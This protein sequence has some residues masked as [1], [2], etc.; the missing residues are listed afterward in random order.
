Q[1]GDEERTTCHDLRSGE[2]LWSHAELVRHEEPLGGPGPRAT[3]AID[4]ERVFSMGATGILNALDLQT[5][6]RLWRVD[7]ALTAGVGRPIYGFAASPVVQGDRVIVV[8]GGN[9]GRSLYA[10]DKTTGE[11]V[12]SGGNAPYGYA[13]PVVGTVAGVEQWVALSEGSVNGIDAADGTLLWSQAWP[14]PTEHTVQP[15]LLSGDRVLVSSGYGVGAKMYRLKAGD[16]GIDVDILWESIRLKA[17]FSDF[18]IREDHVY[19]LDDGILTA[20]A[21]DDGSRAWKKGRYGHGQ[22]LLVDDLLLIL[23]EDGSVALVEARPDEY[24]EHGR[25][26]VLEGKTWNHPALAGSSL[27][28]RN[29]QEAVLLELALE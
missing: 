19:G 7:V 9:R 8:A 20:V 11:V 26:P 10:F 22:L 29:A 21:L 1:R 16:S 17:K 27:L 5:G 2:V 4:G 14:Q 24:V 15:K 28:V 23:A 12:W 6:E 18:V 25:I 3:P 13:T